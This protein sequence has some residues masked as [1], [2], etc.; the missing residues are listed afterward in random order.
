[1]DA[2][3]EPRRRAGPRH[4]SVAVEVPELCPRFIA[5]AFTDVT[6]GPSPLW[7]QARLSRAGMRSINN[8]VDITNYVML[9]TG[10][11]L[12]AFDLDQVPAAR[13]SFAR[14]ATASR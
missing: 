12:H 4:A 9:M 7:L 14:R 8:V 13:S 10:Q 11:P 6:V 1:M 2:D 3:A 5:R